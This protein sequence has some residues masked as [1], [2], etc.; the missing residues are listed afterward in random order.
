M[1]AYE[2]YDHLELVRTKLDQ[3]RISKAVGSYVAQKLIKHGVLTHQPDGGFYIFVDFSPF[4]EQINEKLKTNNSSEFCQLLLQ[5]T[6]VALLSGSF[7]MEPDSALN[8]RLAFVDFDG[9]DFLAALKVEPG[10]ELGES[11]LRTYAPNVVDGIERMCEW[12]DELK[13]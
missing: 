8:A 10:L 1:K 5:Q 11:A 3:A 9:G 13:N 6:G 2:E 12:L 7:F 4:R